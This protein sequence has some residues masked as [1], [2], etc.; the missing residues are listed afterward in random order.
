MRNTRLPL[1]T[2][3]D[4]LKVEIANPEPGTIPVRVSGE[5]PIEVEVELGTYLNAKEVTIS[6]GDRVVYS[7]S[8]A[9]ELRYAD[10]GHERIR[11]RYVYSEVVRLRSRA[12]DSLQRARIAHRQLVGHDGSV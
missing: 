6:I 7:D 5:L 12:R 2:V 3:V 10:G 4:P 8:V 9:P 11:R 1:V